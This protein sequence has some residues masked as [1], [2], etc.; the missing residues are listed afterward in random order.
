[1]LHI[2]IVDDSLEDRIAVRCSLT[3]SAPGTY[4][5]SEADRGDHA[6]AACQTTMPDCVL[7]NQCL[8][9]MDGLEVLATLRTQSDVPVVLL[10]DVGNTAMSVESLYRGA[11]EYLAKDMHFVERLHV[12]V[13]RAIASVQIARENSRAHAIL[14]TI[15]ANTPNGVGYLDRDLRYQMV[16]PALAAIN[17]KTPEEHIGRTLGDILPILAPW[18]EPM[19]RQVLATG[20]MMCDLE[21]QGPPSLINDVNHRWLL[22][23]FPVLGPT[24]AV[25]GVST[26]V[27]DL[28]KIKCTEAA[29]QAS[30]ERFRLLAEHAH[31]VIYRYRLKPTLQLEYLSPAIERLTGYSRETFYND[32]H[33]LPRLMHPDDRLFLHAVTFADS[34]ALPYL[35][36]PVTLR[37]QQQD[38]SIGWF[39]VNSWVV[40]DEAGQPQAVEGIVRDIT[41]RKQTEAALEYERQQ[42]DAII[43]TMREGVMAFYPD[44]TIALMNA[45]ARHLSGIDDTSLYATASLNILNWPML[46]SSFDADGRALPPEALP[47]HRV[48][49]G[50]QFSDFEIYLR[51]DRPN[52]DRWITFNGTPVYDEHGAFIL[53]IMTAQDITQRK[54]IEQAVQAHTEVLSHI[55]ADLSRALRHK[56]EFL[57]TMSHELR[58]PLNGI[59]SFAELLS[60]EIAGPLTE[61]QRR[62]VQY[63]ETSGKHLLALINDILDLAKVDAD[64][65]EIYRETHAISTICEASL[66]FVN[67]IATRKQIQISLVYHNTTSVMNT[68]ARRLKQILVNLLGNAVKFTPA[69]GHVRL[70]VG[71]DAEQEQITFVVEDT[72]IGIAAE[73][74]GRLFQPFTQIDNSLTRQHEGTGLGLALVRRLV[75]LLGGSVWI[76]SAGVGQGSRA[77]LVLPL[78]MPAAPAQPPTRVEPV[79]EPHERTAQN[80]VI[81]LA[82]DNETTISAIS[83]YLSAHSYEVVVARTGEEA[84]MRAI[85]T[86]P[87]LILMDIQMPVMDGLTATRQL[88]ALPAFAAPPIIALTAL[89]MPEDRERCLAAGV[90]AYLTKPASLRTLLTT[91][92][93]VLSP[94][95]RSV[96]AIGG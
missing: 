78:Q 82:E 95:S 10:S 48:L 63:I 25:V 3:D 21:I 75:N 67:E 8:P 57:A 30:E 45:A 56:D 44:G 65:M 90:N 87:D 77:T 13:Q 15:V 52:S 41:V 59:L 18:L 94:L 53:G 47:H 42:L 31:D 85:E 24:G 1:M 73:D 33:A 46:V 40:A 64:H 2:L 27:T 20:E 43:H 93:T 38:G 51:L 72:G 16:N 92:K 62:Q 19:L 36:Q 34:I 91:I 14:A 61:R 5:F 60:E 58:T 70:E 28:S 29:L 26:V 37:W 12:S 55:N 89:A 7:L 11:Q 96:D 35:P 66:L 86:R 6:L 9:D 88:R 69:G 74:L 17:K 79:P 39:E 4:T 71:I 81:L 32:P 76:E 80:T 54:H 68:D 50:E 84:I 49:R 83:E 22:N 23:L